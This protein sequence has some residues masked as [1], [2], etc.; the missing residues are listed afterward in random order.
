MT[1]ILRLRGRREGYYSVNYIF[2]DEAQTI[3]KRERGMEGKEKNMSCRVKRTGTVLLQ[4]LHSW[5]LNDG[6]QGQG[7]AVEKRLSFFLSA[8]S[9]LSCIILFG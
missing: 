8:S 5:T 2:N 1:M 6:R 9:L 4:Q 7:Y 3:S